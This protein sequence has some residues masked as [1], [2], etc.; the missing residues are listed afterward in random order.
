[1]KFNEFVK[2]YQKAPLIDSSTFS[3]YNERPQSLRRQ[4]RDWYD[5]L[6]YLTTFKELEPNFVMLNKAI[7]QTMRKPFQIDRKNWKDKLKGA[8]ENFSWEV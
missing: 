2:I 3:L 5:L 4:V 7:G 6:W 1:M 8:I